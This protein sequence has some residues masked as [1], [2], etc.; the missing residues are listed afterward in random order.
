MQLRLASPL[1]DALPAPER[2]QRLGGGHVV[3]GRVYVI[4]NC[5]LSLQHSAC[6]GSLRCQEQH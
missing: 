2:S 4:Q 5:F 3:E 6:P 1:E